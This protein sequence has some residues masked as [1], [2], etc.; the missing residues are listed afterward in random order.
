MISAEGYQEFIDIPTGPGFVLKASMNFWKK[1]PLLINDQKTFQRFLLAGL[2][3]I[4][5]LELF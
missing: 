1:N 5:V 3:K 4:N 2:C